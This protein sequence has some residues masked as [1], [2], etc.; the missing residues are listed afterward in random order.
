MSHDYFDPYNESLHPGGCWV[1]VH[2]HGKT[3]G[4]P[5][6]L[7]CE[8]TPGRI[9]VTGLPD[10]GCA[11]WEREVGADDEIPPACAREA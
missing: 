10:Y 1:C 11:Y 4:N 6:A 8:R 3:N 2:W 5:R 9:S 7:V